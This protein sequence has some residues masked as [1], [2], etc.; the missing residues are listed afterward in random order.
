MKLI[1]SVLTVALTCVAGAGFSQTIV[2]ANFNANSTGEGS[3]AD[4]TIDSG[5]FGALT[6]AQWTAQ[7]PLQSNAV[8]LSSA[9]G[10][11]NGNVL[12]TWY[13]S[14]QNDAISQSLSGL[15]VGRD[16]TVSF[17]EAADNRSAKT[18]AFGS[19][20]WDVSLGNATANST[21]IATPGAQVAT[22]WT[23][24]HMNFVATAATETLGFAAKS[25]GAVAPEPLLLLDGVNVTQ[26]VPEP[27]TYSMILLGIAIYA[28]LAWRRRVTP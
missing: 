14:S 20:Y 17:Y 21:Y 11:P 1:K 5:S 6:A 26:A 16:Y 2:N 22:A 8:P 15:T 24:V 19:L 7:T 3:I 9:P 13:V 23:Q 27:S 4:W 28:A 10:N 12:G 18:F 25:T